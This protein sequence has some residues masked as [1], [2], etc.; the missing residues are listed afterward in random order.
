MLAE[1]LKV[2]DRCCS[3]NSSPKA[4][5]WLSLGNDEGFTALLRGKIFLCS[6]RHGCLP[7]ELSE[8]DCTSPVPFPFFASDRNGDRPQPDSRNP[9]ENLR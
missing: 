5:Y 6:R 3:T 9:E 7:F 4:Y 8:A 2:I 1:R